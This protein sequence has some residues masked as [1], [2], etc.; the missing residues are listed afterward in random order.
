MSSASGAEKTL[1]DVL[2]EAEQLMMA[3]IPMQKSWANKDLLGIAFM[4]SAIHNCASK[5]EKIS[6]EVKSILSQLAQMREDVIKF[7]KSKKTTGSSG[8]GG[9]GM[10]SLETTSSDT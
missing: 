10:V 9:S 2:G 5:K 7:S 1:D 6:E 3:I 4:E 8:T